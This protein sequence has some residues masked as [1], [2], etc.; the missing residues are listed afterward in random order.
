MIDFTIP[1][2]WVLGISAAYVAW[3]FRLEF[4]VK[5]IEERDIEFFNALTSLTVKHESLDSKVIE[6]LS[7]I[8]ESLARIE[9]RL[10]LTKHKRGE[11]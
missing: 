1:L 10:E 5:R 3:L 7:R 8:R 4:R 11:K 6:E 9:G 2:V